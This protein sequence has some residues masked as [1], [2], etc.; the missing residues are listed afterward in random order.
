VAGKRGTARRIV[1]I[2]AV[3]GIGLVA[4]LTTAPAADAAQTGLTFPPPR[5]HRARTVTVT[6]VNHTSCTLVGSRGW[7]PV[8]GMLITAPTPRIAPGAT[9]GWESSGWWIGD[10]STSVTLTYELAGCPNAGA[11]V[12]YSV[13]NVDPEGVGWGQY[14]CDTHPIRGLESVMTGTNGMDATVSID[15]R[16]SLIIKLPPFLPHP[17]L[18]ACGPFPTLENQA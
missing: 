2:A 4:A 16:P 5:F 10:P 17:S 18:G 8:Y 11:E 15:L 9:G 13:G 14:A 12:G 7:W 1:S 6:L 3:A